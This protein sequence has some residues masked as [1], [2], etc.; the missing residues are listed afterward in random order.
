M[1]W[2]IRYRGNQSNPISL[3]VIETFIILYEN[4]IIVLLKAHLRTVLVF[5]VRF[6]LCFRIIGKKCFQILRL[7]I[8]YIST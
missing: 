8:I 6:C 2:V 3:P 1:G 4:V 7:F 5:F